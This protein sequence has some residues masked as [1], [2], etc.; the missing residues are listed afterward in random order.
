VPDEKTIY[1]F[2]RHLLASTKRLEQYASG[3][4]EA[5][6]KDFGLTERQKR[7]LRSGDPERIKIVIEYEL[8]LD[9]GGIQM[10][11]N[12]GPPDPPP[13]RAG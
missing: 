4:R 6:M 5:L 10:H 13:R 9:P 11:I 8:D 7:V 1:E 12:I 2:I 3:D